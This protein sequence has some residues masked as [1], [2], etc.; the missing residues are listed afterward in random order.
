[1]LITLKAAHFV[2]PRAHLPY[3]G[4]R[5]RGYRPL[6][7]LFISS[8]TSFQNQIA[9]AVFQQLSPEIVDHI[10]VSEVILRLHARSRL[11]ASE[12][13]ELESL[14]DAQKAKKLY[15]KALANKGL[16]ALNDFIDVLNETAHYQPHAELVTKLQSKFHD[17]EQSHL[18]SSKRSN[19]WSSG[20]RPRRNRRQHTGGSESGLPDIAQS[21]EQSHPHQLTTSLPVETCRTP[22]HS[23][24]ANNHVLKVSPGE[25]VSR[26]SS[27]INDDEPAA[28]QLPV[29]STSR[30]VSKVLFNFRVWV[31]LCVVCMCLLMPDTIPLSDLLAITILDTA[32]YHFA[33]YRT[34]NSI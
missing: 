9:N 27:S 13:E 16:P 17:I 12:V 5:T 33:W 2:V 10:N 24:P 29:T 22:S 21:E 15:L 20:C 7:L 19:S 31:S 11:T 28:A 4:S 18:E 30:K 32:S 8:M 14:G 25:E 6:C 34:Y 1:M 26:V 3:K 23:A